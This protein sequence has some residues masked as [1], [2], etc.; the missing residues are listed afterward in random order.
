MKIPL[1]LVRMCTL[2]EGTINLV[3]AK[4]VRELGAGSTKWGNRERRVGI[5]VKILEL[6]DF[7]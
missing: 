1:G 3:E 7:H 2:T 6:K 5:D 4:L